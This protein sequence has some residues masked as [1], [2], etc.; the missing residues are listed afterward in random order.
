MSDATEIARSLAAQLD[1]G[2][3]D[4]AGPAVLRATERGDF[5]ATA[6][7]M[8]EELGLALALAPEAA[9]GAG[10]GWTALAPAL[11]VLG[12][13]GAPVPLGE[14][15]LGN[16][17]L[18][19]AGLEPAAGVIGLEVAPG[20]WAC[21][22]HAAV[23]LRIGPDGALSLHDAKSI[24][25]RHGANIGREPR[26]AT[27]SLGPVLREGRLPAEEAM[28]GGALLRSLQSAGA[29]AEV[30]ALTVDYAKTRCQFGREIGR[31]QA[32]QQL[33]AR[34]A[35]EVAACGVAAEGAAAVADALGLTGAAGD[36]AAAKVMAGEA[37]DLGTAVAHQVHG[38][39]GITDE[40]RLHLLT[41]R[42]WAWRGEFGSDAAWA[43][44]LGHL[45]LAQGG[46]A[47]WPAV[48]TRGGMS[49]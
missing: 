3:A 39:I 31:F 40:H 42:L 16:A 27:D 21:G 15:M 24:T 11:G 28:L 36:I 17:L 26:D 1:R 32:V 33:L 29:L 23:V 19:R 20:A 49:A 6:W 10:L 30:L 47:L 44:R 46:P 13:H 43:R 22:R 7:A 37:I 12:R 9:G 25:W 41:R 14:A 48:T 45:T 18:T 4:T 35:G 8:V 5:P 34:M 38:A 2:L